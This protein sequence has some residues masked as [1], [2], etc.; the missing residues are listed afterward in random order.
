MLQEENVR[1]SLLDIGQGNG[2]LD[3]TPKVQEN[4]PM[5]WYLIKHDLHRKG[6]NKV[7]RQLME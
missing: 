1:E 7:K 3:M 6:N 5:E 4:R 2:F